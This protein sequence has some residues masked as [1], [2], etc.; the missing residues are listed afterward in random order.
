[1]ILNLNI[2]ISPENIV[3][4]KGRHLFGLNVAKKGDTKKLLIVE[5]YMD[6]IS[7]HQRGITNVVS[8]I[9]NSINGTTGVAT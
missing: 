4:S 6:V 8:T 5:G 2:L 9:R 7:L 1:M 3:Y